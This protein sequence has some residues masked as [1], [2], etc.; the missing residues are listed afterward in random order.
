METV[1]VALDVP[2]TRADPLRWAADYCRW[3]GDEL[4]GV[5]AY[6]PSQSE[7]PPDWYEE[8][9]ASVRKRAEAA[10]DAIT[11]AVPHRLHVRD[12]DPRN[13]MTEAASDE[14]A[15]LVVIGALGGGG[16]RGL[17]LGSVAH[18]LARHLLV[19]LVI[20]PARGGPLL[21]GP[22]VVGLD[23][24]KLCQGAR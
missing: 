6:R 10:L 9:R 18:H 16:F 14:R 3:N 20:A 24:Y 1:V 15:A 5:V 4:V 11:P 17:G 23:G 12:G 19:P 2:P 13:V 22:V 8:E 21:G 7:F